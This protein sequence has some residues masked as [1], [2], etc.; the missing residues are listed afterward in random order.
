MSPLQRSG[1]FVP[2]DRAGQRE[3]VWAQLP[4]P[5]L[6]CVG[7]VGRHSPVDTRTSE[8]PDP[9]V[10]GGLQRVLCAEWAVLGAGLC[11][12]PAALPAQKSTLGS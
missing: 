8:R 12:R 3:L 11:G 1:Y 10:G 2:G 6:R 7:N 5:A 9:S 4:P